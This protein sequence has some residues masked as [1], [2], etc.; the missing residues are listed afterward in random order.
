MNYIIVTMIKNLDVSDTMTSLHFWYDTNYS[1]HDILHVLQFKVVRLSSTS[2]L[3][4][5]VTVTMKVIHNYSCN[6]DW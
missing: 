4:S 3:H 1:C 5:G 2:V 6:I